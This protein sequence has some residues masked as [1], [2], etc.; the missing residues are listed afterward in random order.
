MVLQADCPDTQFRCVVNSDVILNTQSGTWETVG[1]SAGVTGDM[2]MGS[3]SGSGGSSSGSSS[4]AKGTEIGSFT[5]GRCYQFV[6]GCYYNQ[7][8]G[9]TDPTSKCNKSYDKCANA[10]EAQ[11]TKCCNGETPPTAC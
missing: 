7:C 8:S 9:N 1:G 4:V 10:C 6:V 2:P 3:V 5:M 11:C